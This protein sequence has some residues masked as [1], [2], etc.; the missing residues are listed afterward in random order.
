MIQDKVGLEDTSGQTLQV[1]PIEQVPNGGR[2]SPSDRCAVLT[3]AIPMSYSSSLPTATRGRARE[4]LEV[5][6][7]RDRVTACFRA[8]ASHSQRAQL[9]AFRLLRRIG[10]GSVRSDILARYGLRAATVLCTMRKSL[11]S[12]NVII[13]G[14]LASI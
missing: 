1:K 4:R 3:A 5:L 6:A 8:V 2:A 13:D 11:V 12:R 14:L 7:N 9:C 10:Y